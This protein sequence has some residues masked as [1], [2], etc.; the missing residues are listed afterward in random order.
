MLLIFVLFTLFSSSISHNPTKEEYAEALAALDWQAVVNDIKVLLKTS[1]DFWP[2]DYGNYGPLMIRQAWHCAGSYRIFDGHGGCDGGR[3]RFEPERSWP[4]NTNLDKTK[5]LLWPVKQK[6]GIGLSWGDLIILTANTAIESM[7]GPVFGFCGGRIDDYDGKASEILGPTVLQNTTYPCPVNGK[8]TSP[9]GTTTVGLIYLNPEGP[10]GNPIPHL[11]ALDIRF[12]FGR[13]D[14][15]DMETVSLIGGGHAFGKAHGACPAGPGPSPKDDPSNPWP[16]LCGTGKGKDAY[17]SG[18]EGAWTPTPTTWGNLYFQELVSNRWEVYL[19]PGKLYQ[20]RSAD[21]PSLPVMMLTS[22]V[23][24]LSDPSFLSYVNMFATNLTALNETFSRTW[25]KLTSRDMG[26]V[27][28]C[29]GPWVPPA[30]PFQNPLPPPP[31]SV[32]DF[33]LVRAQIQKVLTTN[34]SNILPPDA[35]PNNAAYY[36]AIYATLAWQCASTFRHTDYIGG[37]NGARIRFPPQLTWTN[38]IALDKALTL[39]APIQKQFENLSWAD[40]IV[41]AGNVALDDATGSTPLSFCPGRTDATDGSGASLLQPLGNYSISMDQMKLEQ[42]LI[43][44]TDREYVVLHA[45]LRSPMQMKRIGYSGSWTM[46]PYVL[47]NEYFNTLL[48]ETWVQE[49]SPRGFVEYRA[50]GKFIYM[51]PSDL[52]IRWDT[53]YEAI[54]QDFA[55][56]NNMFLMEFASAWTKVMNID[57]FD[58]PTGNLCTPTK[59]HK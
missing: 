19:G 29:A 57:R 22:D 1:Q 3:Q 23:S 40:L 54:A 47:S 6:Y 26:P 17:T 53:T 27:T 8:C 30:Q 12:A 15:D 51:T 39:L 28:R 59:S 52:G 42:H 18:F 13:M 25:Y 32:P 35:G 31:S 11:S 41:L 10:M 5:A 4:D 45:R 46:A 24:L 48:S 58:G 34:M 56:D 49:M 2:A 14:M 7:G 20:W 9:F 43:G 38:N 21:N 55:A 16:G 50:E 36:G 37:C 33:S 44:L